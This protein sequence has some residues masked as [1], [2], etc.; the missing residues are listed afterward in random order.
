M[1]RLDICQFCKIKVVLS[2]FCTGHIL[3]KCWTNPLCSICEQYGSSV[4]RL[5]PGGRRS[6]CA[7]APGSVC[8]ILCSRHAAPDDLAGGYLFVTHVRGHGGIP[9]LFQPSQL[10][11]GAGRAIPDGISGPNF[12]TERRALVGG[13]T[14]GSSSLLGPRAGHSLAPAAWILVGARRVGAV[15]RA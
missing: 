12:R 10:P 9:P 13:A 1:F 14:P 4:S 5:P 6:V 7:V 11:A 2:S 8:R 3:D 15:E